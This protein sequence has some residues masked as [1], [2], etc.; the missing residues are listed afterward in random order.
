MVVKQAPSTGISIQMNA[1]AWHCS[2]TRIRPDLH[3]VL[4]IQQPAG[5]Q[6]FVAQHFAVTDVCLQV[7]VGG[8]CHLEI[9]RADAA[10]E[11]FA[12]ETCESCGKWALHTHTSF[13]KVEGMAATDLNWQ[14]IHG[15]AADELGHKKV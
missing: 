4:S 10:I 9:F 13:A 6:L 1:I 7:S 2:E 14:N 12:L 8:R 11:L 15:W 5:D 3:Q